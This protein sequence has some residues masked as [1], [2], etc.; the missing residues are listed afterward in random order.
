MAIGYFEAID[1]LSHLGFGVKRGFVRCPICGIDQ[2]NW[3]N[4][5]HVRASEETGGCEEPL[6]AICKNGHVFSVDEI[7][8]KQEVAI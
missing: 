4:W 3:K 2:V 7:H 5:A 1:R 6:K 8:H